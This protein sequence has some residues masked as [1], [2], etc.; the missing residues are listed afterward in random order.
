ML[1]DFGIR[2]P[3]GEHVGGRAGAADAMPTSRYGDVTG[4]T[5]RA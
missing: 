3:R 5:R 1:F 4:G 2:N